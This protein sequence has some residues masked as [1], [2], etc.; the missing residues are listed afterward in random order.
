VPVIT[1]ENTPK[2]AVAQ[3]FEKVN[4]GG[5][6]LNVFQLL[7]AAFA[8][9][10]VR[11]PD[12]WKE[13]QQEFA[14]YKV[15]STL[16][17][18][19]FLQAISLLTTRAR[20]MDALA[21]GRDQ[22][23]AP[24]ITCKRKDMLRMTSE[25]YLKWK[26][27][28]AK[29]FMEAA[30]LLHD[31][32]VYQARDLPYRTQLVPLAAVFALLTQNQDNDP[33]R[34][35][36]ARWFW[37]GVFGELYS[38]S[39]ESRFAL[40]LLQIPDWLTKEG[41]EPST[42]AEANFLPSRLRRLKTRGS[43]AYKGLYVLMLKSGAEDF[44]KGQPIS[45][46]SYFDDS[47]DIHHVFPQA[48]CRNNRVPADSCDSIANKTPLA[49]ATNRMLGGRAP[50]IYLETLQRHHGEEEG[51][52]NEILQESHIDPD[53]LRHDDFDG[54]LHNREQ[55]LLDLI[56]G[57]M[58]KEIQREDEEAVDEEYVEDPEEAVA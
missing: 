47:I 39:Y 30:K 55:R 54:F 33:A 25:D 2:A 18:V 45:S 34:K 21:Q 20:R 48:W 50:S 22:E 10:E 4:T 35:K 51:R 46:L 56:S 16:E 49:A 9:D 17:P 52:M 43:A 1:L 7:T 29:G 12:D 27:L 41:Q 44:L 15:L 37:S 23:R 28:A 11:L 5:V 58:G 38:G 42:C 13:R 53:L 32:S 40:D 31:Q 57:A 14:D 19:D 3:I 26:D 36:L 24:G 8:V 6:P